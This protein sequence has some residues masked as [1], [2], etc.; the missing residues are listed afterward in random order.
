MAI[1][2]VSP[3]DSATTPLPGR[4]TDLPSPKPPADRFGPINMPNLVW[5]WKGLL[6]QDQIGIVQNEMVAYLVGAAGE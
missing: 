6:D 5:R 3:G 4:P 2:V 1:D